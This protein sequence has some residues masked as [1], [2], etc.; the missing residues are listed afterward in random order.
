MLCC[1]AADQMMKTG[2]FRLPAVSVLKKK[3]GT[4]SLGTT[5]PRNSNLERTYLKSKGPF[6]RCVVRLSFFQNR[7]QSLTK[8][9]C[10]LFKCNVAHH[11][12]KCITVALSEHLYKPPHNPVHAIK[13]IAVANKKIAPCERTLKVLYSFS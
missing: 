2:H 10:N 8:W 5:F 11:T 1:N 7:S 3:R 13:Y 12:Q 4:L 9:V 6:T